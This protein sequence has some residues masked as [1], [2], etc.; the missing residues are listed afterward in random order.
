MPSV[1]GV[2]KVTNP[3]GDGAFVIVCEHASNFIP[4]ELDNLGLSED[5]LNS[6][7]SWDPG[8]LQVAQA[9]SVALDAALVA[10]QVSRVVFDCNRYPGAQSAVPMRS[11]NVDIPGNAGLSPTA[12][13]ARAERF[14]EPFRDALSALID[15]RMEADRAPVILTVHSFSPVY[16]GVKRDLDIGIIH[17]E[18]ARFANE[19][20]KITDAQTEFTV[21]R[22]AP[23]G[24]PDGVT[25]TL[26]EHAIQRGLLN[27]MIE[28]RNDL[29]ATPASQ[30]AMAQWQSSLMTKALAAL[31]NSLNGFHSARNAG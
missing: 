23:Y 1:D 30:K 8:A 22:N 20:L 27:V 18:D 26:V 28:I 29:I 24:P 21:L 19:V 13:Q 3:S 6:H 17:D 11:E 2:V 9:M 10:S 16:E 7:I 25:H 5:A 31:A 15:Q 12:L 14:Y 4:P